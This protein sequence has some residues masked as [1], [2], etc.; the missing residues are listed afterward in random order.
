[1]TSRA[2][3]VRVGFLLLLGVAGAVALVLFLARDKVKDGL[4]FETYFRESVQGLDVGAPVKFRG[5][6][7]G[8]VTDIGLVTAEYM[9]DLPAD[10]ERPE[11]RLVVVRWLIDPKRM[12]RVPDPGT[13][14]SLGLRAR[15]GSQGITGLVYIE[16]DFVDPKR[17]PADKVPWAP[18]DEYLP[19]M[20]STI[21][22]VS[23]T[24]QALAEKLQRLDLDRMAT[25]M[26]TV[27]DDIHLQLSTGSA[28]AALTD[29]AAL[30]RT[31]RGGV[32]AAD[33]PGTMAELRTTI[34]ALHAT[35]DS[36]DTRTLLAASAQAADRLAASTAK[37]PALIASLDATLKRA[38]TGTSDVQA[39]LVPVL[40]DARAA[41]ANL[42]ETTETL[43]RYPASVLLG[44]PPP[45]ADGASR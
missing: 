34:A 30:A 39:E 11:A 24:A 6:T 17:F 18:R 20:P 7:L 26:Q 1:M 29:I 32:E 21:T 25:A 16:L 19:S 44:A 27:L 2:T 23:D 8:Q 31:L 5:V 10:R 4:R 36:K 9:G 12:G 45:R 28:G 33:L 3:S 14:V 40:R 13:A 41:V 22:Q 42:R 43:R 35:L 37:L 15:L 38:N